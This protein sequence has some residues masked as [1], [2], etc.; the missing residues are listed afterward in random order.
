MHLRTLSLPLCGQSQGS[1][2]TGAPP[3]F[4][5]SPKFSLEVFLNLFI[6]IQS[7]LGLL[8]FFKLLINFIIFNY[9]ISFFY[10]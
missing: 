10:C 8:Q 6:L 2:N 3:S 5:F 7:K 4:D 1:G 9:L